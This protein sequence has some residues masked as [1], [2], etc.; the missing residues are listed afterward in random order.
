MSLL[1]NNVLSSSG[2]I[3]VKFFSLRYSAIGLSCEYP[4]GTRFRDDSFSMINPVALF[5]D[6]K[7]WLLF[8]SISSRTLFIIFGSGQYS[9][10][11]SNEFCGSICR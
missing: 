2:S 6:S 11:A 10:A 3:S 5:M 1:L 8:R 9:P 7:N 4:L